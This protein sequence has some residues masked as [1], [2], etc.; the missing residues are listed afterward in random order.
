MI[1]SLKISFFVCAV[2]PLLGEKAASPKSFVTVLP[3]RLG[4]LGRKGLCPGELRSGSVSIQGRW[5]DALHG[6]AQ[7]RSS[8]QKIYKNFEMV[9]EWKH[10]RYAGNAGIFI[11]CPRSVLDKLP[12]GRLPQGIEIQILDL[13]YEENHLKNKGKH[14]NWFTSHGGVFPVGV[15]RMKAFTP[16]ITY[17]AK[18][19]TKYKVGKPNS[20]RSFP[21]KRLTRPHG[22]W[23]HYYIRAINGEVRLWVNR[24]EVSGGYD[25]KPSEGH[26]VMESEGGADRLSC[27]ALARTSL[28]FGCFLPVGDDLV[29]EFV[30]LQH[31]QDQKD[32]GTHSHD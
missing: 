16:E 31:P 15:G 3:V 30:D 2:F 13:G 24:E 10:L 18:D 4:L 22:H 29:L 27:Y 17:V 9:L 11:W 14:S 20:A 28:D 32:Q 19:G 7:R 26:L 5:H 12:R 6:K 23:N 25:C 21:T 8:F 1:H